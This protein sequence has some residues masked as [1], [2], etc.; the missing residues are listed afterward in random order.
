MRVPH[1]PTSS[2]RRDFLL[3]SG[4]G[5]GAIAL[6]GLL[7]SDG[8]LASGGATGADNPLAPKEPH[9]A[10]R[11]RRVIYLFMHGGPSHVDLFDPKPD[12]AKYAGQ[13]LPA[14]FG[15]VMT[16]RKVAD[17]PLLGPVRP[18]RPR[19]ESGIEISDFLPHI[20]G[21]ADELCVLRSCH[22]DSVNH[23][24][25]VYQMNT[26]SILM[27]KPSLGSWVSYG[28]GSE[29]LDMP[30]FVVMPDPRG[31][32]KGGPPASMPT[33]W[34]TA[35]SRPLPRWSTFHVKRTPRKNCTVSMRSGRASSV[36][37]ACWPGG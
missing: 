24:Q 19:G 4:G 35:C 16:R 6:A 1:F 36:C 37:G 7:Q 12:L 18:F 14:S 11:A 20:A 31:G 21:V 17:N 9:F 28:L 8:A 26:G 29:N 30:A 3:H 22:G 34:P 23:P 27:G 10:A 2:S 33:N 13:P 5:F 25:S 15:E 32:L